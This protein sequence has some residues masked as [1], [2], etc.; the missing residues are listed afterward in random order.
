[1]CICYYS[2]L[3][4]LKELAHLLIITR[5]QAIPDAHDFLYSVYSVDKQKTIY[6]YYSAVMLSAYI[7]VNTTKRWRTSYPLLK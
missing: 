6:M 4:F 2:F 7:G 1:M 5:P 3:P